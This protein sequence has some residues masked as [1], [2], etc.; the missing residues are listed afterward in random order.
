[1]TLGFGRG[2]AADPIHP[3]YRS[4]SALHLRGP[5]LYRRITTLP[6]WVPV[7]RYS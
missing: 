1:M 6:V 3:S 5:M 4:L 2:S 7:A